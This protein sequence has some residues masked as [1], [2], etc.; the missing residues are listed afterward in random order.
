MNLTSPALHGDPD[1]SSQTLKQII[2]STEPREAMIELTR[3]SQAT[4]AQEAHSG[5]VVRLDADVFSRLERLARSQGICPDQALRRLI[6]AGTSHL[7]QK[8]SQS[9][10]LS[11]KQKDVLECLNAGLSVKEIGVKMDIK[12]GTVRTH[13]LRLRGSLDCSDLLSLRFQ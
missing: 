1:A 12:E 8:A 5:S 2:P 7:E 10:P 3:F 9:L 4:A 13:I 11:P 6:I